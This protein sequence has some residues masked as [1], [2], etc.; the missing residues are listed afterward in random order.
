M[1]R[2]LVHAPVAFQ[3]EFEFVAMPA[4]YCELGRIVR[5]VSKFHRTMAA[6]GQG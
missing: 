6:F 4:A 3:H 2:L 5:D 1:V